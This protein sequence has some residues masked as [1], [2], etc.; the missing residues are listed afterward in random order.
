MLP[1]AH[2]APKSKGGVKMTRLRVKKVLASVLSLAIIMSAMTLSFPLQANAA[3]DS[4][5]ASGFTSTPTRADVCKTDNDTVL[6]L[7]FSK[8]TDSTSESAMSSMDE[9][10]GWDNTAILFQ[11]HDDAAKRQIYTKEVAKW[12]RS[13]YYYWNWDTSFDNKS[14]RSRYAEDYYSSYNADGKYFYNTIK[15]AIA[16]ANPAGLNGNVTP[17]GDHLQAAIKK[18][19][20][21]DA[22][23]ERFKKGLCNILTTIFGSNS[24]IEAHENTWLQASDASIYVECLQTMTNIAGS[25]M[26]MSAH[27][28]VEFCQQAGFLKGGY[29]PLLEGKALRGSSKYGDGIRYGCEW[30]G[31]SCSSSYCSAWG[32]VQWA[33]AKTFP[34]IAKSLYPARDN[35][36][37]GYENFGGWAYYGI[38]GGP[39]YTGNAMVQIQE[40]DKYQLGNSSTE[41]SNYGQNGI[42][43]VKNL[44]TS[45]PMR[46]DEAAKNPLISLTST[47]DNS[48]NLNTPVS[49]TKYTLS[50]YK[51]RVYGADTKKFYCD[52][53][54]STAIDGKQA[55]VVDTQYMPAGS[56]E[57][58]YVVQVEADYVATAGDYFSKVSVPQ[59]LL[60]QNFSS[61]KSFVKGNTLLNNVV[62]DRYSDP[63]KIISGMTSNAT[64]LSYNGI[65]TSYG[66]AVVGKTYGGTTVAKASVPDVSWDLSKTLGKDL[67]VNHDTSVWIT[68]ASA[69]DVVRLA[70]WVSGQTGAVDFLTTTGKFLSSNKGRGTQPAMKSDA[71]FVRSTSQ[72][73]TAVD[74]AA[75]VWERF[76]KDNKLAEKQTVFSSSDYV[77]SSVDTKLAANIARY[78]P[79]NTYVSTAKGMEK[80]IQSYENTSSASYSVYTGKTLYVNPEVTMQ[81]EDLYGNTGN[82]VTAGDKMRSIPVI[83]YLSFDMGVDST[84]TTV[85]STAIANDVRAK[86][87]S[88]QKGGLPVY[89]AGGG[90]SASFEGGTISWKTYV[91]DVSNASLRSAWGNANYD[92]QKIHD[93][94]VAGVD[95]DDLGVN[96][97]VTKKTMTASLSGVLNIGASPSSSAKT[98]PF[99]TSKAV[100]IDLTNGGSASSSSQTVYN[101]TIRKG[102]I[103]DYGGLPTDVAEKMKLPETIAQAFETNGGTNGW[104]D[105]DSTALCVRCFESSAQM[106]K[107]AIADKIPLDM[108]ARGNAD[109]NAA[110]TGG[111]CSVQAKVSASTKLYYQQWISSG[112]SDSRGN[113]VDTSH[114]SG[115]LTKPANFSGTSAITKASEFI[116]P[117]KTVLDINQ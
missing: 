26:L 59:N 72:V 33:C 57:N 93:A 21:T 61:L 65:F 95:V 50:T 31:H 11:T 71:G 34:N 16:G 80:G 52:W 23:K 55:V 20:S 5:P 49:G 97:R 98:I 114:W 87:L 7:Q 108:G 85:T 38:G 8:I 100:N 48:V 83:A 35:G 45:T 24:G 82:V 12:D 113:W 53:Q 91:L 42:V 19:T 36:T 58:N 2:V 9:R 67:T 28:Y 44:P 88:N 117:N 22:D 104:Y 107:F 29:T 79:K 18:A 110:W 64:N 3:S 115:T 60:T 4:S 1:D 43:A 27:S 73:N 112:H 116:L 25:H 62:D 78:T 70:S 66:G 106:P 99:G 92:P 77:Q 15:S 56:G 84:K 39:I 17:I 68:R 46:V 32:H 30:G 51:Y 111:V 14:K 86:A 89:L 90:L 69:N 6:R 47:A 41:G 96:K 94:F 40:T 75:I 101:L 54:N 103:T 37:K 10:M 81:Y 109:K 102:K 13:G 76:D 63:Q 105:E 74:G